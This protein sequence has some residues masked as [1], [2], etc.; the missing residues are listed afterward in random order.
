M[1][2]HVLWCELALT[3]ATKASI[4]MRMYLSE[5][6]DY[7]MEGFFLLPDLAPSSTLAAANQLQQ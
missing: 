3:H 1:L 2:T 6:E 4:I 7:G 5:A